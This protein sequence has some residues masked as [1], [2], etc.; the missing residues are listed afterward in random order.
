MESPRKEAVTLLLFLLTP[1]ISI[2][3]HPYQ[4]GDL[5][6]RS[7]SGFISDIARNFSTTDKRFSHVGMV[8]IENNQTYIIHT[9][10]DELKKI[11]HTVQEPFKNFLND[12]LTWKIYKLPITQKE[13]FWLDFNIKREVKDAKPFDYHFDLKNNQN[14]YC[15]E[16]IWSLLKDSLGRDIITARTYKNRQAFIAID[17]ILKVKDLDPYP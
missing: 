17:D 9:L 2:A 3:Q 14:Y 15:T 1:L 16:L 7:G 8:Y 10:D 12:A 11:K 6:F 5:I 4:T 13:R